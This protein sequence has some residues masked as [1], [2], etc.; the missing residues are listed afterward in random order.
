MSEA[1]MPKFPQRAYVLTLPQ[2][3]ALGQAELSV[4]ENGEPVDDLKVSSLGAQS[5][6]RRLSSRERR[7][8]SRRTDSA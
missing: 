1:R 8:C 5:A 6:V 4:T 7:R 2:A 3:Q